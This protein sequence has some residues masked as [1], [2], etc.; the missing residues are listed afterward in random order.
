[1][2][3]YGLD[4]DALPLVVRSSR[5]Q[6][7]HVA[8]RRV[9]TPRFG[10]S[11]GVPMCPT[12]HTH[13]NTPRPPLG[14]G[15]HRVAGPVRLGPDDQSADT[16]AYSPCISHQQPHQWSTSGDGGG[17][18]TVLGGEPAALDAL[19]PVSHPL[20]R[21]MSRVVGPPLWARLHIKC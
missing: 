21:W 15:S 19:C 7:Q 6:H 5:W 12:Y 13:M 18:R 4:Q 10:T 9:V 3:R 14:T 2:A 17:L 1:M 8:D 11:G 16:S 20:D